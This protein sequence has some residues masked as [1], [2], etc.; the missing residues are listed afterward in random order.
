MLCTN[1]RWTLAPHLRLLTDRL[2]DVAT[3]KTQRLIVSMPPGHGK[4]T[5]V[6]HYFPT[7]VLG[8]W[9]D[10]SILLTSYEANFAAAWGRQCRDTLAM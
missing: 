8:R 10:E 4:S 6:S 1:N 7:W 5:L 3:G 2:M 9:P